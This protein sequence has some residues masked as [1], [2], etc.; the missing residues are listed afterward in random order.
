MDKTHTKQKHSIQGCKNVKSPIQ[1][2]DYNPNK[3]YCLMTAHLDGLKFWDIR[4][5]DLPTKCYRDHKSLVLNAKYNHSHDELITV[6]Y[7]E[8][9]VMLLRMSSISSSTSFNEANDSPI[10][11]YDEHEDSVYE[12]VW[13]RASPWNFVSLSYSSANVVVNTVPSV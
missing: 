1:S 9:T 6:S 4:K 13:S 12:T 10:R 8:G 3:Q 11:L 5:G 2:I 7:D